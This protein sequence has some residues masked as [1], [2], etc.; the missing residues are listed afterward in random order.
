MRIVGHFEERQENVVDN[1]LKVRHK[2]VQLED[3]AII[4]EKQTV[5][6]CRI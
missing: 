1:L 3:I 4:Y 5:K 6:I 2:L